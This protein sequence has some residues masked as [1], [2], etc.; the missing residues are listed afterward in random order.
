MNC[1]AYY[2][3]LKSIPLIAEIFVKT[4][5]NLGEK[6]FHGTSLLGLLDLS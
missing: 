3:Y 2:L 5:E 4:C 6:L 1:Q